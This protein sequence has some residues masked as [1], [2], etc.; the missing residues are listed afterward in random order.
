MLSEMF[1]NFKNIQ[2]SE[3]KKYVI[4]QKASALAE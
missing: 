1:A 3:K 2:G 4:H